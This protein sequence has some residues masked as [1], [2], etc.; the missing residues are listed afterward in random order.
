MFVPIHYVISS[1]DAFLH[2]AMFH[3]GSDKGTSDGE[4]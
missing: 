2:S 1:V 4:G 3:A